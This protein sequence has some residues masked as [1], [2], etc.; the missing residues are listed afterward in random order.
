[1]NRLRKKLRLYWTFS[2]SAIQVMMSYRINFFIF[3]FGD[4]LKTF[5]LYYIWKAV[6]L[7]SSQNVMNGFS[8]DDMIIYVFISSIVGGTISWNTDGT[9]GREVREGSIAMN[10]IKP[11]SYQ[12]RMF[13]DAVGGFI[14]QVLFVAVP[15]WLGLVLFRYFTVGELPPD[16]GTLLTFLASMLLGFILVFMLNFAFGVLAFYVTSMWGVGHLKGAVISFFSGQLIPIA[17]FPLWLQKGLNLFPFGAMNYTPVMV[18]LKKISG[19][20]IIQALGLQIFWIVLLYAVCKL[21]WGR[22]IKRLTILGG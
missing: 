11:I 22:A 5:V 14:F 19:V 16:I 1:M 18:Y 12:M 7:S 2:R 3:V 9:I 15:L 17:F 21:V 6:F 4:L 10:L 13:F 8:L 20:Q